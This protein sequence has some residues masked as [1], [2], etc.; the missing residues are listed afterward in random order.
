MKQVEELYGAIVS[1]D[2]R[3]AELAAKLDERE[4]QLKNV[5]QVAKVIISD[6]Y[7]HSSCC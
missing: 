4:S 2:K 5:D 3:I 1:K 7:V 6:D